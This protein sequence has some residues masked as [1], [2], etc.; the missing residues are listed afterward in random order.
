M[1]LKLDTV[2]HTLTSNGK[3]FIFGQS[4]DLPDAAG[5]SFIV[6]EFGGYYTVTITQGDEVVQEAKVHALSA[7]IGQLRGGDSR[8]QSYKLNLDPAEPVWPIRSVVDQLIARGV[9]EGQISP[10]FTDSLL[11]CVPSE[12]H[13]ISD[14]DIWREAV[15]AV[16][17][18][19][20][21]SSSR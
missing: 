14:G 21:A 17:T 15:Q 4:Y 19:V 5:H 13:L 3:S 9:E 20:T 7:T 10:M 6:K 12:L 8:L 11:T 16:T 1:L 18:E 2:R